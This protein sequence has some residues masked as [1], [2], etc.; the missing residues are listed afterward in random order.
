MVQRSGTQPLVYLNGLNRNDFQAQVY[1]H[2]ISGGHSTKRE[3][4][5]NYFK[6]FGSRLVTLISSL[7]LLQLF[8]Q[9]I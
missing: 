7:S 5:R 1:L 8:S 3:K 2:D 4:Y 6:N 9:T